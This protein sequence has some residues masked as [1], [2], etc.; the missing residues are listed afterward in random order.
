MSGLNLSSDRLSELMSRSPD[1]LANIR[2]ASY[3]FFQSQGLPDRR[4]EAW[5]FTSLAGLEQTTF[6]PGGQNL[7]SLDQVPNSVPDLGGYRFVMVNGRARPDLSRLGGLPL[8]VVVSTLAERLDQ[9]SIAGFAQVAQT[10]SRSLTALNDAGFQDGIY[11]ELKAGQHLDKPLQWVS[12][13]IGNESAELF[14]PR[15]FVTLGADTSATLVEHH[16]GIS[17][18]V[19]C[20]NQVSEVRLAQGANLTHILHH[21]GGARGH[22]LHHI[23]AELQ[24]AAQYYPFSLA[25]SGKL[26]RQELQVALVGALAEVQAKGAYLADH[27]SHIDHSLIFDHAIE[28][29]S[30][31]QH[32][33]G[34]IDGSG[35]GVFQGKVLVRKDAQKTDAHQLNKALLLGPNAQWSSKP[36]LEIYADDVQCGHGATAGDL[37]ND[38][39]FYLMSRGIDKEAARQMLVEG[40]LDE[41]VDEVANESLAQMLRLLI[42]QRI[43]ARREARG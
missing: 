30:S 11:L 20:V 6:I 28:G 36:E 19:Y 12:I 10:S 40:F 9:G 33:K 31:R 5:K 2:Q 43:A 29:S 42:G 26:I 41:V 17:N 4:H 8:G 13:M 22:H 39:L 3:Q 18:A 1:W 24:K 16:V 23:A 35:H 14:Q 38:A 27:D 37:D 34:V 21:A 15:L 7:P 32:F 25:L